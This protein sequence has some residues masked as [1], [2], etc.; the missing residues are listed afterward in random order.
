MRWLRGSDTRLGE[1]LTRFLAERVEAGRGE[2]N[3]AMGAIAVGRRGTAWPYRFCFSN[4]AS[5]SSTL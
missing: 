3:P 5:L 2:V 4:S 1:A